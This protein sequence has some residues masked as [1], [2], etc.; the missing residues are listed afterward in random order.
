MARA[1]SCAATRRRPRRTGPTGRRRHAS[2]DKA[3]IGNSAYRRYLRSDGPRARADRRR[4]RPASTASSCSGPTSHN[5]AARSLAVAPVEDLF[6]R[7]KSSAPGR[8][9]IPATPPSAATS[10]ALSWRWCPEGV[11][12]PLPGCNATVEWDDLI[13]DL[14]R[15]RR[16][17]SRRTASATTRTYVEGRSDGSSRPPASP[18]RRLARARLRTLPEM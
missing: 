6:R 12:R 7:A 3:L 16:R 5:D 18:C 13:R 4:T 10:S 14:D 9:I 17:P 8:S 15:C 11:G 1:T 2:G